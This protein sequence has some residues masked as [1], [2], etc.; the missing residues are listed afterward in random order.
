MHNLLLL[1]S[2]ILFVSGNNAA[3]TELRKPRNDKTF[4]LIMEVLPFEKVTAKCKEIGAGEDKNGC[5]AFNLD[6]KVCTIY[7]APQRYQF[8]DQRLAIIGHEVWH[9]RYGAWHEPD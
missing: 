7:V 5:A 9:C 2:L 3:A 1:I 4:T 8:D 6:T